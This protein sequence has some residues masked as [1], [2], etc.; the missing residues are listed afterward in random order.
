MDYT[1]IMRR[2]EARMKEIDYT[3][4]QLDNERSLLNQVMTAT[5]IPSEAQLT[6]LMSQ[7]RALYKNKVK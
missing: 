6:A 2:A 1:A 4:S 3:V 5:Q 7:Y